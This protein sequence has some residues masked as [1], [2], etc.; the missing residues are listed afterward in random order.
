MRVA[1][2]QPNYLPWLGYFHKIAMTDVFVFLDDVQYSKGSYTNRVQVLSTAGPKWLTVPLKVHFGQSIRDI[3]LSGPDWQRR[4]L[5]ALSNYY[6]CSDAYRVVWPD[7]KEMLECAP[8]DSLSN[9][10]SWLIV[11]IAK[12]L[13]LQCRFLFSSEL[14]VKSASDNRLVDIAK[15]FGGETIYYSGHG[16]ANYQDPGKFS[17]AGIGFE[18]S[19]YRP[20][21]YSQSIVSNRSKRTDFVGG[22]SIVDAAFNL[23]WDQ[24]AMLLGNA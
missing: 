16:A 8:A 22:L 7:V 10:N 14:D 9:L 24:T 12:R 19:T 6:R 5:E 2:H 3:Q 4:H 13:Q 11:E 18:Y 1:I 15:W 17:S 21:S 20:R 23:G